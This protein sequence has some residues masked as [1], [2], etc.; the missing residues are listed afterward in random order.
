[1]NKTQELL[2][3]VEQR[4][5]THGKRLTPPRRRVLKAL[6]GSQAA[7]TAYE[8]VDLLGDVKPMTVYRALDFLTAQGLAHRIESLNAYKACVESHCAHK[9]SQYMV[10]DTCGDVQEIHN[11]ALDHMFAQTLA[12]SGFSVNH[13]VIEAHGTCAACA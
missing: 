9:D 10:C 4:L 1:M 7:H 3:Q 6:M 2:H 5:K 12:Q 8:I 11:H 13:K